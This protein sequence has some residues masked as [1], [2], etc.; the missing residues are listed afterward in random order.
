LGYARANIVSGW[1]TART[2]FPLENLFEMAEILQIDPAYMMALYIE[3]YS[4][5]SAPSTRFDEIVAMLSRICTEEEW[6]IIATIREARRNN[7][8]PMTDAQRA[9]LVKL[10]D[11]PHAKPGRYEPFPVIVPAP[12]ESRAA[13][14]VRRGRMRDYSVSELEDMIARGEETTPPDVVKKIRKRSAAALPAPESEELA[15]SDG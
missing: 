14:A 10:F 12:A 8:K 9:G 7:V 3:Q 13:A 2:K 4:K 1:K 11:E 6:D 5:L 15:K